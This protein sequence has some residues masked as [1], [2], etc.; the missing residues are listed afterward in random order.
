MRNH[1]LL[2]LATFAMFALACTGPRGPAGP[3]GPTGMTGA[4]GP[5]GPMGSQ[6]TSGSPIVSASGWNVLRDIM[7]DF[8]SAHIRPS[9]LRKITEVAAYLNQNPSLSLGIDGSADQLAQG[10][11]LDDLELSQRRIA[12]VRDALIRAGVSTRRI[13]T[14]RFGLE[15]PRCNDSVE[16]CSRREGFVGILARSR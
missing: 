10:S 6:G 15:R 3:P 9:E 5:T 12:N 4:Q 11:D 14:G 1:S 2:L 13:E 8:D 7:F 16:Q